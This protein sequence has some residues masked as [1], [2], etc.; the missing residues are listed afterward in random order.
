M[1]RKWVLGLAAGVA[2]V[3]ALLPIAVLADDPTAT[4]AAGVA[5]DT[6]WVITA[7]CLVM[8]M[9]AGFAMLEVG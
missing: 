8:F 1:K 6:V 5:A 4:Q 7:A 9:Q 2:G 3:G